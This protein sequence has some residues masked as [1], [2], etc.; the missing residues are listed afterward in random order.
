MPRFCIHQLTL[1]RLPIWIRARVLDDNLFVVIGEFVDNVFD[2]FAKLE[3]IELG[4]AVGRDGDTG[5]SWGISVTSRPDCTAMFLSCIL[6]A[7]EVRL[8]RA[9][10]RTRIYSVQMLARASVSRAEVSMRTASLP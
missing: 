1:E 8:V 7:L 9:G 4:D 2:R 10:R 5:R 6:H 3:L